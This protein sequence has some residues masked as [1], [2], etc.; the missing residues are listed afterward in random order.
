[1]G[2]KGGF[3]SMLRAQGGKMSSKKITNF[4]SCRDLSG[5]RLATIKAADSISKSLE[6]AEEV[7]QK[8]K[9]RLKRKIE[10]GLKDYSNK[11]VFLDDAAFE[12][13]ISKNE[14]KTRKITQNGLIFNLL[15]FSQ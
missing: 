6:L 1:M 14:K 12:K 2:G 5:R 15:L 11:K 9:E 3:G 7:E 8:K 4:D 13:E 10:K